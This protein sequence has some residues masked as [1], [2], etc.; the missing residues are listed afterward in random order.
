MKKVF[1][2]LFFSLVFFVFA[3]NAYA[4]EIHISSFSD[5]QTYIASSETE[6]ILDNDIVSNATITV[7]NNI[8]INGN[9]YTLNRA[10]DFKGNIFIINATGALELDNLVID[11]GA[12]GWKMDIE[13]RFYTSDTT[14]AYVRFPSILD[15][16]DI[17]AT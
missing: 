11:G 5:L 17:E 2:I 16:N 3:I 9:N 13:N 14:S 15:D 12:S 1:Y 6:F 8:K 7:S 4:D 10:S